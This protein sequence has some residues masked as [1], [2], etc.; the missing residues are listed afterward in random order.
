MTSKKKHVSADFQW[1]VLW[2]VLHSTDG[3]TSQQLAEKLRANQDHTLQALRILLRDGKVAR[4][5]DCGPNVHWAA[6]NL[7]DRVRSRLQ[8]ERRQ[9]ARQTS[10]R[11]KQAAR[12]RAEEAADKKW[13]DGTFRHIHRP[14]GTWERSNTDQLAPATWLCAA[15]G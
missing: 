3:I 10:A 6:P 14:P 9:L 13:E 1:D 8:E 12:I 5:A 2:A 11:Q 4:S 7:I 15:L